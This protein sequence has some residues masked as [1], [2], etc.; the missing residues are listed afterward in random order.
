MVYYDYRISIINKLVKKYTNCALLMGEG[1][2]KQED[3]IIYG[4][5]HWLEAIHE[6][7][8][9][10]GSTEEERTLPN[11]GLN[12]TNSDDRI[13]VHHI[14][15]EIRACA[16]QQVLVSYFEPISDGDA[17]Y[18]EYVVDCYYRM[19]SEFSKNKMTKSFYKEY[20]EKAKSDFKRSVVCSKLSKEI[21]KLWKPAKHV[22]ERKKLQS[23]VAAET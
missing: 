18:N 17:D 6:F 3:R 10:L 5:D 8:H 13:E 12:N 14:L 2:F 16:I 23:P 11:L 7:C 19:Q 21:K 22:M 1:A 9:W 15:N 20:F 4:G